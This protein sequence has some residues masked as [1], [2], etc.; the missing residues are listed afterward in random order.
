M[1]AMSP[2]SYNRIKNSV[3]QSTHAWA[4]YKKQYFYISFILW[5]KWGFVDCFESISSLH[6][7][8]SLN[9]QI[10]AIIHF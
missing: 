1:N 2:F 10:D 6:L 8:L 5:R 7:S 4:L 3:P 9:P